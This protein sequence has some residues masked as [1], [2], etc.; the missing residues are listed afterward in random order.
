MTMNTRQI[1]ELQSIIMGNAYN[2]R[3][4]R[5]AIVEA[6]ERNDIDAK[7]LLK[8]FL[9]GR[10]TEQS[11]MRLQYF[12]CDLQTNYDGVGYHIET[13]RYSSFAVPQ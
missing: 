8:C 2:D 10:S 13:G 4:L 7:I 6:G 3:I 9:G 1:N 12:V 5:L 11:W